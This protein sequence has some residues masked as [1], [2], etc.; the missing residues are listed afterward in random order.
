[1]IEL[2]NAMIMPRDTK[3]DGGG[4]GGGGEKGTEGLEEKVIPRHLGMKKHGQ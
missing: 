3:E 4:G 2:R 1:M